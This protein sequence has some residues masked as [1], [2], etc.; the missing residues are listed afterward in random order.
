MSVTLLLVLVTIGI[1]IF[2]FNDRVLMDKLIFYP[3]AINERNQYY[4]FITHGFIHAD[5][6]H[7]AFNMLALYTFGKYVE[8]IFSF[9]C[10]FGEM[11]KVY[12]LGMYLL[13]LIVASI[14]TYR[15]N[16]DNYH[17]RSLGASGAVSS[18]IFAGLVFLPQLPIRFFFIPIDI[19]GYIFG[20]AYLIISAFLSRRGGGNV[21]HSAHFWGAAFGVAFTVALCLAITKFDIPGNFKK[22]LQSSSRQLNLDC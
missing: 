3:P 8:D 18:V 9:R 16:R 10:I 17:Y 12:Y 20:L 7:L 19:P 4:R 6:A 13:G 22:Q 2:A 21:N 15:Q 5:I 1:S 11:G 14:P